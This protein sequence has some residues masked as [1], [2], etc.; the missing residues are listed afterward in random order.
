MSLSVAALGNK[1]RGFPI[2][3]QLKIFCFEA[4]SAFKK[5]RPTQ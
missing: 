1:P 4:K 2:L 5:E 3:G